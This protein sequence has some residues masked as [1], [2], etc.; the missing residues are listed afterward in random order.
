[1]R[2][3]GAPGCGSAA[4]EVMLELAKKP[5]TFVAASP[6]DDGP[7]TRELRRINPLGQVPTLV[8]DDGSVLT[9][10]AAMMLWLCE[11]AP[12]MVPTT[13]AARAAFWRWMLFA[14]ASVYSLFGFRDFPERW[15]DGSQAQTAFRQR[16]LETL[17][18]R[19]RQM[20]AELLPSPWSLGEEMSAFDIY[21]AMLSRWSPGRGWI[22]ENCPKLAD[23][24]Q[25][26][27]QHPIVA[28]VW[29]RNFK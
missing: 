5:Y 8:R 23:V 16:L 4:V 18:A 24:V 26:T 6:W 21:L 1:M 17:Q 27:E 25:R 11:S 22:V 13:P 7:G 3:Y 9:E 12:Q 19:W 10:S 2:L 20:E 15:V 28:S 29:E 14:A